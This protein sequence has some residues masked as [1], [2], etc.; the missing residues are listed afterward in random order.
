MA[1]GK[2]LTR[3]ELHELVW[4]QPMKDL[5][6]IVGVSAASVKN[7]CRKFDIPVPDCG[8]WAKIK[9]GK[10]TKRISLPVRAPGMSDGLVLGGSSY[11]RYYDSGVDLDGPLPLPPTF[12][13]SIEDIR[14]LVAQKIGRVVV[15]RGK[16][17]WHR[18]IQR[19]FAADDKRRLKV[20]ESQWAFA[21]DK[22]LFDNSF[23]QRRLRIMNALFLSVAKC[24]GKPSIQG[25]EAIDISLTVHQQDVPLKILGTSDVGRNNY[26]R[27]PD[28]HRSAKESLSLIVP[29]YYRGNDVR[30]AWADAPDSKLETRLTE[31]AVELVVL[32][33]VLHRENAERQHELLIERKEDNER[34]KSEAELA[35]LEAIRVKNEKFEAA[36][37]STLLSVC[38]RSQSRADAAPFR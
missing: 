34:R 21:W 22:P 16:H 19:L 25:K 38:A 31:I 26:Y 8:H 29:S 9:A 30:I 33:E 37:R 36:K 6:E 12:V 7:A 23:E 32:A 5:P 14:K 35:R 4:S 10:P 13:P 11:N 17:G 2:K 27:S 20:A 18:A 1:S 24:G 3:T 28:D 15:P